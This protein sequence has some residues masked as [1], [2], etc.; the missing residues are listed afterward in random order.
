M[1]NKA[2]Q[3][4]SRYEL[5]IAKKLT[6]ELGVEF[7]RTPLSGALDDIPGDIWMPKDSKAFP[8]TVECKHYKN[9][10]WNNFLTAKSNP[11]YGFFDQ[12]VRQAKLADKSPLV[13]FKQ[14]RGKSYVVY[15]NN[16]VNVRDRVE[17]YC[18]GYNIKIAL[19]DDFLSEL[20]K[21]DLFK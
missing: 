18:F 17:V 1:S 15:C 2:K 3:K 7:K 8:W 19:L 16:V 21:K 4:G 13:I 6:L 9:I 20:K 12:A 5:E 10:P 14:D 11:I